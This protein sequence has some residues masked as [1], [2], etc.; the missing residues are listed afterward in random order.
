MPSI[1]RSD[2]RA[3]EHNLDLD[4][5]WAGIREAYRHRTKRAWLVPAR[6]WL[7]LVIKYRG[8][9]ASC[10]RLEAARRGKLGLAFGAGSHGPEWIEQY[11]VMP[12]GSRHAVITGENGW[13]KRPHVKHNMLHAF[14]PTPAELRFR[15]HG[16][17]GH[18]RFPDAEL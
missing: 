4:V 10:T 12:D 8:G 7:C 16:R 11:Q 17:T 3:I 1:V 13:S 2:V 9:A 15:L 5:D 18:V 6:G 14:L